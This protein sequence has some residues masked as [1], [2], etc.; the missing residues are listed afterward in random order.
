MM[1]RIEIKKKD[2]AKGSLT[3]EN[4]QF[5]IDGKD[6]TKLISRVVSVELRFKAAKPNECI[7]TFHVDDVE[8]DAD[9]DLKLQEDGE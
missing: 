9:I 5:L 8:I 3:G 1:A 7:V 2:E 6:I 4:Y